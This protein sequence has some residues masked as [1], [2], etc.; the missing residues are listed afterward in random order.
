[1]NVLDPPQMLTIDKYKQ[2]R[3]SYSTAA[4]KKLL[5]ATHPLQLYDDLYLTEQP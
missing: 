1:V 4:Y 5:Q 2:K 3:R